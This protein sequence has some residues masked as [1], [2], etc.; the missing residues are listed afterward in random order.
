MTGSPGDGADDRAADLEAAVQADAGWLLI[1]SL[2]SL[3]A[4]DAVIRDWGVE[5]VPAEVA[6]GDGLVHDPGRLAGALR[7]LL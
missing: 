4:D 3:A 6:R 7:A 5:P 1:A 2:M